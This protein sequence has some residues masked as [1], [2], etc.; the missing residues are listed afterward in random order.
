MY[1]LGREIAVSVARKDFEQ[2][3]VVH[4]AKLHT[5]P[6]EL[7]PHLLNQRCPRMRRE[8]YLQPAVCSK[9]L[10]GVT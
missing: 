2:C 8:V 7:V 3:T 9:D 10:N 5:G 4:G 6:L 1:Y